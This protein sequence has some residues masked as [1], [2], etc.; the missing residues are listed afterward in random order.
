M[1]HDERSEEY[2]L[3]HASKAEQNPRNFATRLGSRGIQVIYLF[4]PFRISLHLNPGIALLHL[5]WA[6]FSTS[7]RPLVYL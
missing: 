4:A 1:K 3:R 6:L 5:G 7:N 2:C